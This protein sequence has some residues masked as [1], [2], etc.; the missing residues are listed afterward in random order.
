MSEEQ[1]IIKE[2]KKP[3]PQFVTR[4][5][6]SAGRRAPVLYYVHKTKTAFCT[7]C[8][9]EILFEKRPSPKLK[10]C[11]ICKASV[12]VEGILKDYS[13]T[14][15][16]I[17]ED[18]YYV[19]RFGDGLICLGVHVHYEERYDS[20]TEKVQIEGSAFCY[21]AIVNDGMRARAY[22]LRGSAP[23]RSDV[24]YPPFRVSMS[25]YGAW[26]ADYQLQMWIDRA[27]AIAMHHKNPHFHSAPYPQNMNDIMRY[28]QIAEILQKNGFS[29]LLSDY[30]RGEAP[31]LRKTAKTRE[32]LFGL[33]GAE[34]RIAQKHN[35]SAQ[36]ITRLQEQR[37]MPGYVINEELI[38]LISMT[39]CYSP[40]KRVQER[41]PE[42]SLSD[43]G[44]VIAHYGEDAYATYYADYID[45]IIKIPGMR[46]KRS[47]FFPE[48]LEH[49]HDKAIAQ[50]RA[51][52]NAPLDEKIKA[53]A[54][55]MDMLSFGESGFV[56]VIPK[57]C[58]DI[59][60]EGK[61]LSHCVERYVERVA[62]KETT[63][64][65]V[66]RS[67]APETPYITVECDSQGRRILQ[68]RGFKN[69]APDDDVNSFLERWIH[70]AKRRARARKA[71]CS[72]SV[73]A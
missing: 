34:I 26:K 9:S 30:L 56:V 31:C 10:S 70:R 45:A 33:S 55:E 39:K 68:A 43:L 64:V 38:V 8:R 19:R 17:E 25:Y 27:W 24:R 4:R 14:R 57:N 58:E 69:A 32:K 20:A 46:L 22:S 21:R 66:R 60:R 2:T 72:L 29:H 59:I 16:E 51:I 11:P 36:E 23:V 13:H 5:V 62:N 48:N 50:A 53:R 52:K 54:V 7:A 15:R 71:H 42:M 35:F 44:K 40:T 1:R 37:K 61:I 67:D 12:V 49:A 65:F 6:Y 3:I 18:H 41:L 28:D 63:I 47:V 73:S